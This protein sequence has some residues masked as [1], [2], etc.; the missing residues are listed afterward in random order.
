MSSDKVK[1]GPSDC[2]AHPGVVVSRAL[3]PGLSEG[4]PWDINQHR[5]SVTVPPS[6]DPS[7]EC[8]GGWAGTEGGALINILS[9]LCLR[10]KDIFGSYACRKVSINS[11]KSGFWRNFRIT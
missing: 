3:R 5:C 4:M 6:M 10:L 8:Q 2:E 7:G 1:Q 11:I 9:G